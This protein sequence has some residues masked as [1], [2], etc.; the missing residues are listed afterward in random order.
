METDSKD[1]K[2]GEHDSTIVKVTRISPPNKKEV[3]SERYVE[4]E[5]IQQGTASASG[6]GR[7]T[8]NKLVNQ[9]GT[10]L[11]K[12]ALH[13][14]IQYDYPRNEFKILIGNVGLIVPI[15]QKEKVS[16]QE[17]YQGIPPVQTYKLE[18]GDPSVFKHLIAPQFLLISLTF[19]T[20]Y[21]SAPSILKGIPPFLIGLW[22]FTPP[23][24]KRAGAILK[25]CQRVLIPKQLVDGCV[26]FD[27]YYDNGEVERV[28]IL[29]C[30]TK[31][32]TSL[33]RKERGALFVANRNM[34]NGQI[35]RGMYG[36]VRR[37]IDSLTCELVFNLDVPPS[38]SFQPASNSTNW[39]YVPPAIAQKFQYDCRALDRLLEIGEL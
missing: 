28:E 16:A 20:L 27:V 22:R 9:A 39:V 10:L 17:M 29:V 23:L 24:L 38:P 2:P 18:L 32:L 8:G 19:L 15:R 5:V 11:R 35:T 14:Q 12:G 36:R 21:R 30:Q 25:R 6:L 26:F 34:L 37:N 4:E 31:I 7:D 13:T 33:Q 3:I 1:I